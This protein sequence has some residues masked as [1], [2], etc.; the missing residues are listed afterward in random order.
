MSYEQTARERMALFGCWLS[1]NKGQQLW[2]LV[3][4]GKD[5]SRRV[6][7]FQTRRG[8]VLIVVTSIG[9]ATTWSVFGEA[10]TGLP[11]ADRLAAL[12]VIL[13][14]VPTGATEPPPLC[15]ACGE[16]FPSL[17]AVA[18][19]CLRCS[20]KSAMEQN[21]DVFKRECTNQPG[22]PPTEPIVIEFKATSTE[23]KRRQPSLF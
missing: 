16:P 9:P 11:H 1:A 4:N 5:F 3:D 21:I 8:L 13:S 15:L 18:T 14:T 23:P 2:T 7:C 12:D 22:P 20:Y 6:D 17:D 19:T 10:G